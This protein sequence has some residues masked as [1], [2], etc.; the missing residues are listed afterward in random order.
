MTVAVIQIR[1]APASPP[2][3]RVLAAWQ[4]T[5]KEVLGMRRIALAAVAVLV[6]ASGITG[7]TLVSAVP[8]SAQAS[9]TGYST[10]RGTGGNY[11]LIPTIGNATGRDNCD[12]GPGNNS[13]AVV[14]LQDT[15]NNCYG[16]NLA[17]DGNYGPL[18]QEAVEDAQQAVHI[19]ADGVYGP[20]TRDHIK[21]YDYAGGCARL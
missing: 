13:N 15:L 1:E 6:A 14:I 8:A 3:G 19:P 21:W 2:D 12:L 10:L 11:M 17:T 4:E 9:C 7:M 16:Q 20:Q 18:T 5:G